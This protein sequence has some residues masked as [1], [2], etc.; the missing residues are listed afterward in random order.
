[1]T[2][3]IGAVTNKQMDS[4]CID[5]LGFYDKA[6]DYP[7]VHVDG[8]KIT[9]KKTDCGFI[10]TLYDAY[11][12]TNGAYL[13]KENLASLKFMYTHVYEDYNDKDFKIEKDWMIEAI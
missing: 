8:D 3:V 12:I 11:D 1:M 13:K 9:Y 10:A 4:P 7:Y 2:I 6:K 5:Y